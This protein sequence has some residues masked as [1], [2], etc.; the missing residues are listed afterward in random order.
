MSS[1]LIHYI[2]K[3]TSFE[4]DFSKELIA[5]VKTESYALLDVNLFPRPFVTLP[6]PVNMVC[7][8]HAELVFNYSASPAFKSN[9]R[10]SWEGPSG[11]SLG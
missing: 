11:L 5:W 9:C 3:L 8:L 4:I 2:L 6:I 1:C 10:E 7:G